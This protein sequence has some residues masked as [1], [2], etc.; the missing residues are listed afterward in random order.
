MDLLFFAALILVAQSGPNGLLYFV[1]HQ[2]SNSQ[3]EDTCS[4]PQCKKP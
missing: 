2:G 3:K 1:K 4:V